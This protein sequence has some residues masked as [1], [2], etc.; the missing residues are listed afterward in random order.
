M[1]HI[2]VCSRRSGN[3]QVSEVRDVCGNLCLHNLA[4]KCVKGQITL[5]IMIDLDWAGVHGTKVQQIS[6]HPL[7]HLHRGL[8][9]YKEVL[10]CYKFMILRRP[11]PS[12]K[13][14]FVSILQTWK[15]T[16]L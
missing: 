2:Y 4:A 7:H 8:Q 13:Q 16:K 6:V 15:P 1:L 14:K 12:T 10:S 9:G 11:S 3:G 5:V